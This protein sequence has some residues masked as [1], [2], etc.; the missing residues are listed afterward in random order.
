MSSFVQS[1]RR[2]SEVL[3][4]RSSTLWTFVPKF[5]L[6]CF[7]LVVV[8]RLMTVGTFVVSFV[9]AVAVMSP[10]FIPSKC[11]AAVVALVVNGL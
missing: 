2:W 4:H 11:H 6:S 10:D 1:A 3:A 8:N 9:S 5:V 7:R